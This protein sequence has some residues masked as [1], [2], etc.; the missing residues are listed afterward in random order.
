MAGLIGTPLGK[1]FKLN[2][3]YLS[4]SPI[5]GTPTADLTITFNAAAATSADNVAVTL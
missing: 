5:S 1:T 3:L 4:L 2:F